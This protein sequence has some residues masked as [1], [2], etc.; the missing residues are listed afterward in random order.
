MLR[1]Q[2]SSGCGPFGCAHRWCQRILRSW[3][4]IWAR[5]T[6]GSCELERICAGQWSH[7][8]R[9]TLAVA[10]ALR[11]SRRLAT[12]RTQFGLFGRTP[13]ETDCCVLA[14]AKAKGIRIKERVI[15]ENLTRS[16]E[17]LAF[18]NAVR[19][20]AAARAAEPFEHGN[21]VHV[22][23]LEQLWLSLSPSGEGAVGK[24]RTIGTHWGE[25]GFQ[26]RDPATDLRGMG[27]LSL[28]HL[29]TLANSRPA[30]ARAALEVSAREPAY[31]PFA[32]AGV[33]LTA[34][35]RR[36]LDEHYLDPRLFELLDKWSSGSD[37]GSDDDEAS[38]GAG[39]RGRV[40]S[41]C[42]HSMGAS[43][44]SCGAGVAGVRGP[45]TVSAG[46]ATLG[47]AYAEL[48]ILFS[49]RWVQAAPTDCMAFPQI[50]KA[51]ETEAVAMFANE[52]EP[53]SPLLPPP[54]AVAGK[55]D[56][57]KSH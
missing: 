35:V 41:Q 38:C 18:A 28:D 15:R 22:D 56:K 16:V 32:A 4:K 21:V 37:G 14:I 11:Q 40:W 43:L 7:D 47:E 29:Y 20:A 34:L 10:R 53:P 54:V 44:R 48:F 55:T 33:N 57:V 9:V 39:V 24:G 12:V 49:E 8:H 19:G 2:E 46:L 51:F 50:F 6:S 17:G 26:G 30:E 36:L 45:L 13:F 25:L 52:A 5:L 27:L 3:S 1:R 23:L 42:Y 31:Y